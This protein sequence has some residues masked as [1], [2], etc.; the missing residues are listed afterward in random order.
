MEPDN[1]ILQTN[2]EGSSNTDWSLNG[3]LVYFPNGM[4]NI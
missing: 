4:Q 3:I 2:F 1:M